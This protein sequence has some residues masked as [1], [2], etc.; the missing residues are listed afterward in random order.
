MR[1]YTS[2]VVVGATIPGFGLAAQCGN[3]ANPAFPQ[4]LAAEEADLDL[5][6][7]QPASMFGR[8]MH[9]KTIPQPSTIRF[10]ETVNQ[11]LAG[12]GAQVVHG[13]MN[14]FGGRIVLGDFQD[15]IGK[16]GRRA[17]GRHFSEMNSRLRFNAAENVGRATAFVLIVPSC[18]LAGPKLS[19]FPGTAW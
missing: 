6:L 3:I 11:R 7:V 17:R 18:D 19:R 12:V 15:E 10:A 1:R 5:S 9:S 4:A 2:L 14:G 16:L 13:Q 8:V